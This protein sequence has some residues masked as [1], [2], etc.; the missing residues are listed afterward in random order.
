MLVFQN[1]AASSGERMAS[2]LLQEFVLRKLTHLAKKQ[3]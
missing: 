2:A 1:F 3:Q